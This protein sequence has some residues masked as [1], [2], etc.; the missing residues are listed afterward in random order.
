LLQAMQKDWQ[1]QMDRA[2]ASIRSGLTDQGYR[3]IRDLL[4]S[5]PNTSNDVHEWVFARM[6]QWEDPTH[7]L[8]FARRFI[9]RLLEQEQLYR[10][11]MLTSQCRVLKKNFRL[12][13]ETVERL[14]EY[15]RSIGK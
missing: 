9:D 15:A 1:A 13:K 4:A 7:A 10:A 12:D 3:T 14:A 8:E 6:L 11:L 2:Y 5:S